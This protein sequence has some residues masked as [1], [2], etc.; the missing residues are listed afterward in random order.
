MNVL[1]RLEFE[2]AYYNVVVWHVS[3]HATWTNPIPCRVDLFIVGVAC[4]GV[5]TVSP[6]QKFRGFL[7]ARAVALLSLIYLSLLDY[8]IHSWSEGKKLM[9]LC[10]P[11][12]QWH[13]GKR[14]QPHPVSEQVLST[15]TV[16]PHSHVHI[17]PSI[18]IYIMS[19]RSKKKK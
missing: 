19:Q 2:L 11:Q 16:S 15:V 10:I 13:E 4:V 8:F 12:R 1:A 3:H 5:A 18:Y 7:S 17:Y 14:K 9:D 6:K